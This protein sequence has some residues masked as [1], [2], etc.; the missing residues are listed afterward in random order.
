MP[1]ESIRA[2][3]SRNFINFITNR[4]DYEE[5]YIFYSDPKI[6]DIAYSLSRRF[7]IDHSYFPFEFELHLRIKAMM[8][9]PAMIAELYNHEEHSFNCRRKQS[10]KSCTRNP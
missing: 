5:E 4:V 2:K 9:Y 1:Q 10:R 7:T 6:I 8:E 3:Y